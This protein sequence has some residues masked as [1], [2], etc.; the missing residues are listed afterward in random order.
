MVNEDDLRRRIIVALDVVAL[1]VLPTHHIAADELSGFGSWFS[2]WIRR[3]K[4]K[5]PS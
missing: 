1:L 5:C 2:R 3:N 4:L